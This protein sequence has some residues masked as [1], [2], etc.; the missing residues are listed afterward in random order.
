MYYE[1]AGSPV[2][3]L[4]S[5]HRWP[6]NVGPQDLPLWVWRAY[7][8]SERLYLETELTDSAQFVR[9][10]EGDSLRRRLPPS[11]WD[12]L[13]R[14]LPAETEV[15]LLQPWAALMA[16]P[17]VGRAMVA[18]VETQLVARAHA[19]SKPIRHLETMSEFSTR[20]KCLSPEDYAELFTHAFQNFQDIRR[21]LSEMYGAWLSR[22]IENIEA[23]L[24]R[25][26]L[27][28]PRLA[29]LILDERHL[30]W[31]PYIERALNGSKRTL[32]VVDA[33]HLPRAQGLLN[34]LHQAGHRV[35]L[36]PE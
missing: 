22:Y 9:L 35:Q 33:A 30:A 4:G 7:Q 17:F 3:L 8:W 18:G 14:V 11:I 20:L 31:L 21:V 29:R 6:T 13:Q 28:F 1:I 25:T 2:R 24:P 15:S 10:N 34:L 12:A 19:Q 26:L 36:V 32:I 16:L 27:G 5:M 23:L